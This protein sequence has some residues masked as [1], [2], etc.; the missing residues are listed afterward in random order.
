MG[1][2]SVHIA[3]LPADGEA[4]TIGRLV[5]SPEELRATY[6]SG[7][8]GTHYTIEVPITLNADR[9]AACDARVV[10]IDGRSGQRF[11]AHRSIA[12]K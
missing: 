12:L 5:L 11:E 1:N 9:A 4:F 3:L 6:R 8:T 2:L 7:I 10:Y